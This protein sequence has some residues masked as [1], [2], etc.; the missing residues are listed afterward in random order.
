[1]EFLAKQIKSH[2]YFLGLGKVTGSGEMSYP[3]FGGPNKELNHPDAYSIALLSEL[4]GT[5]IIIIIIIVVVVV[6]V[7]VVVKLI[8]ILILILHQRFRL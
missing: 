1:M 5:L 8:L 7:V 6:V 3:N 4:Q 2:L